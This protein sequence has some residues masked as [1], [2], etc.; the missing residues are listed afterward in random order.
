MAKILFVDD[1]PDIVEAGQIVLRSAGHQ[2]SAAYSRKEGMAAVK[3]AEPDLIILDVMMQE[4]DEGIAMAVD[5]RKAGFKKPILML[6][7]LSKVVGYVYGRED[8]VVPVDD[9]QEK[10]I[11]PK[12]LVAKVNELLAAKPTAKEK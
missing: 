11:D 10:P 9:F 2:V 6:T 3:A 12:T 7:S 1:D 8:D 4:P 5:L